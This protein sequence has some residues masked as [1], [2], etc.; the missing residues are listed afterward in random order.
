MPVSATINCSTLERMGT[1]YT[2]GRLLKMIPRGVLT[3]TKVNAKK[4][5]C[6][7]EQSTS[8]RF[9]WERPWKA[10]WWLFL[11]VKILFYNFNYLQTRKAR[12]LPYYANRTKCSYAFKH[13][14]L[15]GISKNLHVCGLDS[16]KNNVIFPSTASN[17]LLFYKIIAI[18]CLQQRIVRKWPRFV[19]E[20]TE[21]S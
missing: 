18:I 6:R 15:E 2:H 13:W 20:E 8:E 10:W 9:G 7:R 16:S 12:L 4:M 14:K 1:V 21:S 11:P 17:S 3:Q 19:V 5:Q